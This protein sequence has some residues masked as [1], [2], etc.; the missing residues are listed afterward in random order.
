M[1]KVACVEQT[2]GKGQ[3]FQW[4]SRIRSGTTFAEDAKHLRCQSN[5]QIIQ[6]CEL[7]TQT[8]P[9]KQWNQNQLHCRY[10][11]NSTSVRSDHSERQS[12]PRGFPP[13]SRPASFVH[14]REFIAKSKM[15]ITPHPP[16]SLDLVT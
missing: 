2:L 6:K 15:A 16:Y 1:L 9:L 11:R 3:V 13:N 7:R 10:V 12:L 4:F 8:C 5:K 14:A